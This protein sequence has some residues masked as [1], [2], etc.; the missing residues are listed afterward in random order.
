MKT[1]PKRVVI[2]GCSGSGKTTLANEISKHLGV[3]P[4]FLDSVRFTPGADSIKRDDKDFIADIKDIVATDSWLVEGIY[5]KLGIEKFLWAKADLV[6]WLDPPLWKIE[7]RVWKRSLSRL[8]LK[9]KMTSGK[10]VRWSSEFGKGGIVRVIH[11]IHKATREYYP[12]LI[13]S[14]SNQTKIRHIQDN[15]QLDSLMSE[16]KNL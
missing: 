6:V 12:P 8:I 3:E 9:E 7:Y 2:I 13:E 15:S 14:I 4:V 1:I 16:F 11:K 5:Y 10:S